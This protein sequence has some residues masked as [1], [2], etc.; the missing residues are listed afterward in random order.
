M[1]I[2]VQSSLNMNIDVQSTLNMNI[3]NILICETNS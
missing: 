1:N 3:E 2:D